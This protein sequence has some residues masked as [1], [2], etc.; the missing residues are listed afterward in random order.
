MGL[1]HVPPQTDPP[2]TTTPGH[3]SRQSVLA[4]PDGSRWGSGSVHRR[5]PR[6][7]TLREPDEPPDYRSRGDR[8]P[9]LSKKIVAGTLEIYKSAVASLLPTPLKAQGLTCGGVGGVEEGGDVTWNRS[10]WRKTLRG[11]VRNGRS[12]WSPKT[13][14][15]SYR[16]TSWSVGTISHI[17]VSR[18]FQWGCCL[19][20]CWKTIRPVSW[21]TKSAFVLTLGVERMGERRMVFSAFGDSKGT[22]ARG[23]HYLDRE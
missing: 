5:P 6:P 2:G 19:G 18:G 21:K 17:Q 9:G 23:Y 16:T 13:T 15:G 4:V 1:P 11:E 3:T 20:R 14:D 8:G 10:T 22:F 7:W 12:T